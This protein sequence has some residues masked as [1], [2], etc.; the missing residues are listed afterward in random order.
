M[1][2]SYRQTFLCALLRSV[3]VWS[4]LISPMQTLAL[5]QSPPPTESPGT[6]INR[7]DKLIRQGKTTEAIVVLEPLAQKNP[8]V[9]GV[10]TLL[11]RAYF[12]NKTYQ[13][14]ILYLQHAIEQAPREWES[15]QLL[16]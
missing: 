16:A 10:E 6:T 8:P 3:V 13:Q 2:A 7:A 11:G 14:A 15:I 1:S 4:S 9:P 5:G 12:T